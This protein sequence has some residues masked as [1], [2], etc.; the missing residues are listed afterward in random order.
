MKPWRP[1]V[2]RGM[3]RDSNRLQAVVYYTL[4]CV[5]E[6]FQWMSCS[7]L[8]DHPISRGQTYRRLMMVPWPY[9]ESKKYHFEF[10]PGYDPV[11]LD[12]VSEEPQQIFY[13]RKRMAGIPDVE[14]IKTWDL[15]PLTDLWQNELGMPVTIRWM[16]Q[17]VL[18]VTCGGYHVGE[19]NHDYR[20]MVVKG[21]SHEDWGSTDMH[22]FGQVDNGSKIK[23][24][25]GMCLACRHRAKH[26]KKWKLW[27]NQI[28]MDQRIVDDSN[29]K[30]WWSCR[31]A[32]TQ[33]ARKK[34]FTDNRLRVFKRAIERHSRRH[35]LPN[36]T[37]K[38]LLQMLAATSALKAA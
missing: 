22:F 34:Y 33:D 8:Y 9:I 36:K 29:L 4:H 19:G 37:T 27:S 24:R 11:L 32:I 7:Y 1:T 30:D 35:H 31:S 12:E 18:C 28:S 38:R 23:T 16:N 2:T 5:N 6:D 26:M 21:L 3:L 14:I 20:S 10:L 25:L 17:P 13:H 15:E